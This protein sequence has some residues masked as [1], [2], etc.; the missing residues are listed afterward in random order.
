MRDEQRRTVLRVVTIPAPESIRVLVDGPNYA[1]LST[2]SANGHPRSWVVWVAREGDKLLV[3]THAG[4]PK[5]K[6]AH[7]ELRPQPRA[8]SIR[9]AIERPAPRRRSLALGVALLG[10][11][12]PERGRLRAPSRPVHPQAPGPAVFAGQ[13][14]L[15]LN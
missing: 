9:A 7:A 4:A 14:P 15:A 1:H 11:T 8:R 5:A 10:G 6:P 13:R 12:D 2:L 3:C